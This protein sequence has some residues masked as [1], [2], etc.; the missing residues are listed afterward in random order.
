DELD[1]DITGGA[2]PASFE[3]TIDYVV[4]KIPRFAF[5]KLPGSS[6]QLTTSMKSVGEAMAIGRTFK[7]AVQKAY[8]SLET[9]LMGFDEIAV[10]A[11]AGVPAELA[12]RA[13]L[14]EATPDRFRLTA[15]AFREGFTLDDVA[16]I[17]RY[18]KW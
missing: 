8:R 17:T 13:A 14:A 1:N 15:Q 3:P 4:V 11:L 7:E 16:E 18:D 12:M 9:G 2:T 10:P 5:E 6:P